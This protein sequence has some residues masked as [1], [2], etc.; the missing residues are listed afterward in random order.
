[1]NNNTVKLRLA[2]L[3]RM[4]RQRQLRHRSLW[5]LL[6][7]GI[8]SAALANIHNSDSNTG[9]MNADAA[10]PGAA[11][12]LVSIAN[13]DGSK[14]EFVLDPQLPQ[15]K[16]QIRQQ[17]VSNLRLETATIRRNDTLIHALRRHNVSPADL[18]AI[19]SLKIRDFRSLRQ[20]QTLTL[21][22]DGNELH[23]L[24][25]PASLDSRLT[26]SRDGDTFKLSRET[27]DIE[28]RPG[29]ATGVIDHSLYM[30]GQDAGLDDRLIAQMVEM[31]GWDI[32][33]ALDVREGDRFALV[34]EMLFRDGVHVGTG[35]VL[36]AEYI[37]QGQAYRAI[38]H[39]DANGLIGYYTPDGHSLRRTFLRSPVKFSRIS[40][41]F[42]RKRF[43]PVLKRWRAHKGVDYAAPTGTPVRSTANGTVVFA[44][45]KGG[46]GRTIIVRHGSRY[47]TLYAHMSRFERNMRKGVSV[48]QGQLIGRVG[49]TGLA[50]G[51]HL[52]YEFR[53]NN[54]HHNPLNYSFPKS[55][56]IHAALRES[57]QAKAR[58]L[59]AQLDVL[60][61]N[62]RLANAD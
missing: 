9:D 45:W 25:Y 28:V 40:S 42:T 52:H 54:Q 4:A 48:K 17:Q 31:F 50:S 7:A 55:E 22:L 23:R 34:Y 13:P 14:T 35:N 21:Q 27:L 30:A 12:S 3:R 56:P 15:T 11:L 33:F 62:T 19:S 18:G 29:Y 57:F 59:T 10:S 39:K 5:L 49:K 47:S 2:Q 41:R 61:G 38:S 32:D 58:T 8:A 36:A 1:L 46:Y 51:P 53:V 37:N 24:I 60:T 44:G 6:A 26:L 20:G 16:G 43:H